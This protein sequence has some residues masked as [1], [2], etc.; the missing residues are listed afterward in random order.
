MPPKI[1]TDEFALKVLE[2]AALTLDCRAS[3]DLV[4]HQW[5][6]AGSPLNAT[7]ARLTLPTARVDDAGHYSCHVSSPVG[8]MMADFHVDVLKRP[9]VLSY[10]KLVQVRAGED[11]QL[12]CKFEGTPEP[13]VK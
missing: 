2:G 12:V 7:E 6:F 1:E 10:E 13:T 8:I 5:Y 9:R 3:G 11:A 4:S